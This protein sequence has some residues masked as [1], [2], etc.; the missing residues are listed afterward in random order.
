MNN[1]DIWVISLYLFSLIIIGIYGHKKSK[2]NS[3][4]DLYL[5]GREFGVLMLFLTFYAT[6]YSG[7]T[8]IGFTGKAYRD[9]W[10]T[11]STVVFMIA[12]IGGLMSYAPKL[13]KRAKQKS[14]ITLSDYVYDRYPNKILHYLVIGVVLFVLGNYILSNLKAVGTIV[15]T[16][17]DGVIPYAWGIIALSVIIFIYESLGGM[18]SVVLTDAIQGILLLVTIQII[19]FVVLFQYGLSPNLENATIQKIIQL[20]NGEQQVKWLSTL[21]L[22][23]F[24]ISI[25]PHAIQR[26]FM[27]RKADDLK[28]SFKL[29]AFMPFFT[30]LPV[31]IIAIIAIGVL[32][33]L[34]KAQSDHVMPLMLNQ[35]SHIPFLHWVIVLF[36][37]AV[38]AAIMSTIDSSNIAIHSI[39]VKNVYLVHQPNS[40][41]LTT[42]YTSMA[43]SLGILSLL[44]YLAIV[45]DSSIWTIL[46][47][48]LEVLA[49]L[50][51][52]IVLGVWTKNIRSE[53]VLGGL[54]VGLLLVV[55]LSLFSDTPKPWHIHAG[56]WALLANAIV[57]KIIYWLT[58]LKLLKSA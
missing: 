58:R 3:L 46:R 25:Y 20:P 21:F 10:T 6:Q 23:F 27:A 49:Q 55:Y 19:F 34:S 24:S 45:I 28:K 40:P 52:L 37:A 14:Y 8:M 42:K 43:V 26:I 17:S 39:L 41:E 57:I 44:T 35:L 50:F 36:F 13:Y 9:G 2:N 47:I 12:V 38:L 18:R 11:L 54:I 15:E 48:K 16:L 1:L 51:P 32:P 4:T 31:V 30:T 22:F 5:G 33:E 29:M 7:N 53:A 56:L